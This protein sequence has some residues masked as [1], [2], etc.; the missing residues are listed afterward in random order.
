MITGWLALH[1]L[2][3]FVEVAVGG[4]SPDCDTPMCGTQI[5]AVVTA[6]GG[7]IEWS[8]SYA[9]N[10]VGGLV[11]TVST[12]WTLDYEI[13]DWGGYWA[14]LSWLI[15]AAPSLIAST[16]VGRALVQLYLR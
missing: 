6:A 12:V 16:M 3:T 8:I 11:T 1:V 14:W 5:A 15:R 9:R 10:L 4:A 13:L 2:L 7:G